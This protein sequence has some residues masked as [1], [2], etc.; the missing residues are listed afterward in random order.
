MEKAI[1][2]YTE[3]PNQRLYGRSA[4]EQP[5]PHS[6]RNR[7]RSPKRSKSPGRPKSP[8][9]SLT[10]IYTKGAS[11]VPTSL[12]KEI[13]HRRR[14]VQPLTTSRALSYL[15]EQEELDDRIH[16]SASVPKFDET[17]VSGSFIKNNIAETSF[18]NDNEISYNN[19]NE[20]LDIKCRT[21]SA[22]FVE[23]KMSLVPSSKAQGTH[24]KHKKPSIGSVICN[25][26]KKVTKICFTLFLCI[27]TIFLL[28]FAVKSYQNLV[29]EQCRNERSIELP[30]KM[31]EANLSATLFG[32]ELAIHTMI[33]AIHSSNNI[34]LPRILWFLGWTG[35]GKSHSIRIITKVLMGVVHIEMVVP[36]LHLK[37]A[38]DVNSVAITLYLKLQNCLQNIVFIDGWDEEDN[39][40]FD[41]LLSLDK[42]LRDD[43]IRGA[44]KGNTIFVI[45][46]IHGSQEI[47]SKFLD[48]RLS[49]RD[50]R[51][52]RL[53]DFQEVFEG[54]LQQKSVQ[55]VAH[56][57]NII[58]FLPL[59]LDHVKQC[60]VQV[61]A[62][63]T[64]KNTTSNDIVHKKKLKVE[65]LQ[66]VVQQIK[67]IPSA[68]PL[69]S[70]TGCKRVYGILKLELAQSEETLTKE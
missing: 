10:A 33:S 26:I 19:R 66:K 70:G 21:R 63:L 53:S 1:M 29:E 60:I 69:L 11:K 38:E 54:L 24:K 51:E 9:R 8:G 42:M 45:S 28:F 49:E 20:E 22:L 57:I 67:F 25:F 55:S 17:I 6:S 43:I 13:S 16:R 52:L 44:P 50:R 27:L 48:L 64:N 37:R 59:E 12:D 18:F 46:G 34:E 35:T 2:D 61:H 56:K 30:L 15:R 41:L 3:L 47:N 32:Q 4:S 40:A 62:A 68:K 7:L 39:F 31:L 65:M 14:T 23:P 36:S 58:P 5:S